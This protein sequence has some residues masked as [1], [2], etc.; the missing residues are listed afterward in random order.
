MRLVAI[1]LVAAV[2]VA[3][4]SGDS[5]PDTATSTVAPTDSTVA[6]PGSTT[7]TGRPAS[8]STQAPTTTLPGE[9]CV[10]RPEQCTLAEAGAV[11]EIRVGAAVGTAQL[12]RPE[13]ARLVAAEFGQITPE[14]E[15]KWPELEPSP[16]DFRFERADALVEFAEANG[17]DV[18]GHALI[19]GQAAGNGTPEWVR[20]LGSA[21][22]LRDAMEQSIT[23][24]VGRYRGRIA[25]WDV[26]NEPLDNPGTALDDNRFTQLLGAEYIDLAFRLA[27]EADPEA[28]LWLNE[29][30]AEVEPQRADA[31]VALVEQLLERGVPID[32][33]GLQGHLVG[34][35]AP[36]AG[37]LDRLV[38]DLRALGVEVAITELDIAVVEDIADPFE[39]QATAFGG[40]AGECVRAGCEEITFWGVSDADSW[41]DGVLGRP[42]MPLLFDDAL[43]PKPAYDAVRDALSTR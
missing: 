20:T 39:R 33:V 37:Q 26:V 36:P 42:A 7:S 43:A 34:G 21:D 23:T 4:C 27:R 38:R 10:R 3:A 2:V 5:E 16:G 25:R 29:I 22:E 11:H 15:L 31:L 14:N 18:R 32:G 35:D 1:V 13:L 41:L 40:V 12:A 8:S 28:E 30:D 17:L 19:W 24:I 6:E 9:R